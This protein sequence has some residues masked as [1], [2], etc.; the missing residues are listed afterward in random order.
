MYGRAE[1]VRRDSVDSVRDSPRPSPVR[2]PRQLNSCYVGNY[3]LPK[4]FHTQL[5]LPR[6]V[7]L[8][9]A[10][11][12]LDDGTEIRVGRIGVELRG[13]DEERVHHIETLQ[14]ELQTVALVDA[15][16]LVQRPVHQAHGLKP[17]RP[18]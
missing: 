13:V 16:H 15:R 2:H 11:G 18:S 17:T 14:A 7:R 5:D 1:L 8:R 3:E 9:S 12:G 6:I 4:E 10:D